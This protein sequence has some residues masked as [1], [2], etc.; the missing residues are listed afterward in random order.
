VRESGESGIEGQP[1]AGGVETR[2]SCL[3]PVPSL[4]SDLLLSLPPAMASMPQRLEASHHPPGPQML[5]ELPLQGQVP[6]H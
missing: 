2:L 6:L 3:G 1:V 4:P 5:T